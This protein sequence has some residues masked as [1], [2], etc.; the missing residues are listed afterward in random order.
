MARSRQS[1]IRDVKALIK[2]KLKEAKRKHAYK[3]QSN[4]KDF[5][6]LFGLSPDELVV[7]DESTDEEIRALLNDI[8]VD[9][10]AFD[11][12][13][14]RHQDIEPPEAPRCLQEAKD[15]TDFR[16]PEP[17]LTVPTIV[18]RKPKF[19]SGEGFDFNEAKSTRPASPHPKTR[20]AA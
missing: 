1:V 19:A 7:T 18:K 13:L 8:S 3:Y 15:E 10:E 17:P 20:S 14:T 16:E 11:D 4:K 9:T 2:N 5:W 6:R 12:I